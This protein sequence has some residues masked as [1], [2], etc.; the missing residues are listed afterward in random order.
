MV[1]VSCMTHKLQY[2][3]IS[4]VRLI[5]P[6]MFRTCIVCG[7]SRVPKPRERTVHSSMK[8]WVAPLSRTTCVVVDLC[9]SLTVTE[10]V[11]ESFCK[12]YMVARVTRAVTFRTQQSKNPLPYC[13]CLDRPRILLRSSF[14]PM[15]V[16][17][18]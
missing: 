11:I 9:H 2:L 13:R 17:V 4:P 1:L 6:S 12:L 7:N 10:I 8:L 5:V 16:F 14:P 18:E 15:L 3:V